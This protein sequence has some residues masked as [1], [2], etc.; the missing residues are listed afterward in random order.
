MLACRNCRVRLDSASGCAICTPLRKHIIVLGETEEDKPSLSAVSSE[1]VSA[2]RAQL[3]VIKGQGVA[4]L[5]AELLKEKRLMGLANTSAK[6]LESARKLQQDG[7]S[8]VEN[9]SFPERCELFI[10]WITNLA[11][12][13]RATIRDKWEQWEL[14]TSQPLTELQLKEHNDC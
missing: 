2:I 3:K 9:M 1:I 7:I 14:E 10:G 8:A 6:V 5:N 13:Y 12:A 11:P 4:N